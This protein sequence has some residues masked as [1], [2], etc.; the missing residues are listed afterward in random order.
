VAPSPDSATAGR[1]ERDARRMDARTRAHGRNPAGR[2]RH[3]AAARQSSRLTA[4]REERGPAAHGAPA[5]MHGPAGEAREL[6]GAAGTG[7]RRER[8]RREEEAI[9]LRLH[10][11]APGAGEL[12]ADARRRRTSRRGRTAAAQHLAKARRCAGA[13]AEAPP[14]MRAQPLAGAD[15]ARTGA[16]REAEAEAQARGRTRSRRRLEQVHGAHGP[17]SRWARTDG[18][19]GE[20]EAPPASQGTDLLRGRSG[21]IEPRRPDEDTHAVGRADGRPAERGRGSTRADGK[22]AKPLGPCR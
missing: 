7:R 13:N 10:G 18:L 11:G 4:G 9:G 1:G 14:D 6:A 3:G 16:D 2:R 5:Q 22:G 17:A 8:R 21:R 12:D 19:D 20:D 15:E